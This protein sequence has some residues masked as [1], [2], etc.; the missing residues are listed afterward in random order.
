MVPESRNARQNK[1]PTRCLL[2]AFLM[3]VLNVARTIADSSFDM[4]LLA[5]EHVKL[6][7]L[8]CSQIRAG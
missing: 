6:Q 5:G 3:V 7:R 8:V 2:L 4:V 1:Q